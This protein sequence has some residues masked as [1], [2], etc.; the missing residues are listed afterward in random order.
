[1]NKYACLCVLALVC[2]LSFSALAEAQQVRIVHIDV[3]QGDSTLIVGPTKTLLFDAGVTGSGT[4]IR[5]VLDSLGITSI[6]YFVAGHYHADH[7]G[8]IDELINGGIPINLAS[9]DRGGSYSSQ[10]FTDYVNAVGAKRTTIALNQQID[11]GGGC[12]LT[13]IAVNG[14]TNH[15]NVTMTGENDRS[16]ALVLRYGTFDYFIA[17]DLTGGG[18][19][20]PDV[21]TKIAVDAGDV[22]VLHVGHH[23]SNTSTNQTLVDTLKPEQAVIS[24]GDGNTYGH[25]VQSTLDRLAAATQMNTIWQTEGGSGG[26]SSKVKVGGN[27]TFLTDGSTYSVT[28]SSTGQTFNYNTDGVYSQAPAVVINEVA[29]AGSSASAYDEWIELYNTTGS[30]ISL[31]GWKIV[32]DAGAQTYNLSGTIAAN[33]YYLIERTQAVTSV[34]ADVL[35]SGVSLANTGDTLELQDAGGNRVD[36]VNASGG[37]WY[38]GTTTGYYTMERISAAVSGSSASNWS[39]NNGVTRNG[40]NSGGTAING[41]PRAK[42]SV[43][44]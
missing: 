18:A 12:V 7:I 44:P 35:I 9:Y 43:T 13:C 23:G 33:G 26:T 34:T 29:W 11:L 8:A 28:I 24:C 6:D 1:M 38:A 37:A 30:A 3:G 19:S 22:D 4:E 40:T 25:P 21:E 42:N 41:T 32:D 5:A 31:T 27:I 2:I 14:Q 16:I 17:S 20:T 36:I 15:G 10:T 39:N